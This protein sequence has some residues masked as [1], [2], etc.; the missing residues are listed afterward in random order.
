MKTVELYFNDL[1]E[2][3]QKKL[4]EVVHAEKPSDMNWD[5]DILPIAMIDFEEYLL[6]DAVI[7]GPLINQFTEKFTSA[8]TDQ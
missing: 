6:D 3:G 8:R 1:N 7:N 4:L 2:R 5:M